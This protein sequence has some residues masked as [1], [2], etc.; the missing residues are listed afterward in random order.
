[1]IDLAKSQLIVLREELQQRGQ[2]PSMVSPGA[3]LDLVE[4]MHVVEEYGAMCEAMYLIMAADRRVLNVERE[5]MRGA[6]DVLSDG[7]VRTA[8]MEA[9]PKSGKTAA[10]KTAL[11]R[12]GTI[13]FAPRPRCCARPPSRSPTTR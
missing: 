1:M 9:S 13:R 4:A 7:R 3:S 6:L 2:R 11:R 10:F 8:H 5:V 12:C